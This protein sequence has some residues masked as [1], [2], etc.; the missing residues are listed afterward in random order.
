MKRILTHSFLLFLVFSTHCNAINIFEDESRI[1]VVAGEI[2]TTRATES[3]TLMEIAR[4]E[5]LGYEVVANSNRQLDPWNPGSGA[6]VIL[7]GKTIMPYGGKPGLHI[8]LAELRLFHLIDLQD[9]NYVLNVYP[10]GIGRKGRE[11][12]LGQ[13]HIIVKKKSPQWLVPEGLRV[14]D[15][16]LPQVM[17]SGPQNPLGDY[18]LGLSASGYG[19]HGTNR[20]FGV[21]RRVSYGCI[22]LYPQD[23]STLYDQVEIG[24]PVQISYQPIKAAINDHNLL[25][26]V[27]PDY[28]SLFDDPFQHA[29][30]VISKTGWPGGI[31]YSKVRDVVEEQKGMPEI[32]GHRPHE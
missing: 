5:G 8:N 23:I 28:M 9:G 25:L 3:E 32:I 12:P 29:L 13:F 22:R 26:E 14:Q 16:T 31:D 18:W 4:R 10:L 17:P 7:P 19:I 30:N 1:P 21:G 15:P 2:R 20:P 6:E 27:H 11:T 24:T